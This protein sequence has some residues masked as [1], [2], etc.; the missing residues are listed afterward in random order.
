MQPQTREKRP[1]L[2]PRRFFRACKEE[3]PTR[4]MHAA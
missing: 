2:N 3:L 4:D 1:G